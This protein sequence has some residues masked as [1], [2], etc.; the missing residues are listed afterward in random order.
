[1]NGTYIRAVIN[2][3]CYA[4]EYDVMVNNEELIHS[5]EPDAI[6]EVS[7]KLILL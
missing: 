2:E 7:Y 1:V 5:T 3:C 4:E 6:D